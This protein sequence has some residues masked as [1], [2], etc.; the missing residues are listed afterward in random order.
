MFKYL[1]ENIYFKFLRNMSVLIYSPYVW[2]SI[3]N[4]KKQKILIPQ[5]KLMSPLKFLSSFTIA[6]ISYMATR[7]RRH[8]LKLIMIRWNELRSTKLQ[9]H[10]TPLYNVSKNCV[11]IP[12]NIIPDNYGCSEVAERF[13][14]L[15]FISQCALEC[16]W[17][18][19]W[20]IRHK[21]QKSHSTFWSIII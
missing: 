7:I 20:I 3:F 1:S 11:E 8:W 6:L 18:Q 10:N 15:V 2:N 4:K 5:A 16:P 19:P 12:P 13:F 17:S 9:T 21:S 14:V